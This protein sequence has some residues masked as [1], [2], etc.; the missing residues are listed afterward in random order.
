M[1]E[2]VEELEERIEVSSQQEVSMLE[3]LNELSETV[4]QHRG[5]KR[6]AE[7]AL[8]TTQDRLK[9][10]ESEH[11]NM[12][13][14]M[15]SMQAELANSADQAKLEAEINDLRDSLTDAQEEIE[16]LKSRETKQR[17]ALMDELNSLQQGAFAVPL[18][19]F[20]F[21]HGC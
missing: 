5:E 15:E 12:R 9:S 16:E 19:L 7:A 20:H 6:K 18:S 8:A 13:Q 1:R 21:L 11:A 10:L 3:R 4:E 17:S 2:Q 14:S